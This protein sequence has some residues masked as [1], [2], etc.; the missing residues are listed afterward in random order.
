MNFKFQRSCQITF[1]DLWDLAE[2]Y[3][4]H[5][6]EEAGLYTNPW[7]TAMQP[8]QSVILVNAS[9]ELHGMRQVWLSYCAYRD[10]QS[11]VLQSLHHT[12]RPTA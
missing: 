9:S 5:K 2:N 6:Q 1:I 10:T 12:K 8:A 7:F 3:L 4:H 11:A